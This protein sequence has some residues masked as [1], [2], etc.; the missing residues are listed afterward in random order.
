[1]RIAVIISSLGRGGAERMATTFA[2]D[3]ARLGH[4]VSL[5][6]LNATMPDMYPID[7]AVR[8]VRL[9]LAG[10]STSWTAIQANV[11]RIRELRRTIRDLAPDLIVAFGDKTSTLSVFATTGLGIPVIAYETSDPTN[12]ERKLAR[13]WRVLRRIGYAR[14]AA[15]VVL[16]ESINDRLQAWWPRPNIVLIQNPIPAE[17]VDW[18]DRGTEAPDGRPRIVALARLAPEKGLDMLLDA[19]A[20]LA[21]R[22]PDWDLWLWGE[23][24]ARPALET[25]VLNLGLSRR[26]FLPGVTETPWDELGKA[27]IFALPSRREGFPG[28]LVE[29]MAT[30]R[31]CVAFDCR[32]GPREIS[33]DGTD[34]VLV[35]AGDVA[36]FS[37]ALAGLMQDAYRRAA[38]GRRAE[39]VRERYHPR[40]AAEA[41][42]RLFRDVV[43]AKRNG[44]NASSDRVSA[45]ASSTVAEARK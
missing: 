4:A 11:R 29:A 23:G 44:G 19:F 42:E 6:S 10:D 21:K 33:R 39:A 36:A 30:G 28:A 32:S 16:A 13:P 27:S 14:A 15:L 34:A 26:A 8:R 35:P 18:T 17:L 37:K 9:D 45:P 3:W 38:L 43:A 40:I 22:F 41:W 1:M 5:V 31:A 25:R 7:T 20:P 24:P 12:P 2:A